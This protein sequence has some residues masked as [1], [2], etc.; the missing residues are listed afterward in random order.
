MRIKYFTLVILPLLITSAYGSELV[1]KL[2][3]DLYKNNTAKLNSIEVISGVTSHF[4]P[5]DADYEIKTLSDSDELFSG[6]LQVS[7]DVMIDPPITG[8]ALD[9]QNVR[10]RLP[11]HPNADKIKLYHMKNEILSIDLKR[12]LCDN[13]GECDIG[14]NKYIC[15]A[16]C[17]EKTSRNWIFLLIIPV[18]LV[19]IFGIVKFSTKNKLKQQNQNI[20]SGY[21]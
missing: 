17:V 12:T 10:I 21:E 4:S 7:F 3:L 15:E 8:M 16:D 20:D 14:E 1:Y 9:E 2:D 6:N 11:Y 5:S 18:I 13:D 19:L